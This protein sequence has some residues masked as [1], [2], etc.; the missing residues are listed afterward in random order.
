MAMQMAGLH[1]VGVLIACGKCNVI[2]G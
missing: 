2:V 1:L